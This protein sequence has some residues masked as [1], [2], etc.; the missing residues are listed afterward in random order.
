[1]YDSRNFQARP[2]LRRPEVSVVARWLRGI[3]PIVFAIVIGSN[4][5]CKLWQIRGERIAA[6][7]YPTVPNPL[8]VPACERQYIMEQVSDEID[9]YF[10]IR[11][12]ERIRLIDNILTEGSIETQPQIGSTAFEPWRKDSTRGFERRLSTL[13]TIRRWSKVRVIPDGNGYAIDVK[14]YKELEDRDPPDHSVV[15]GSLNRFDNSIDSIDSLSTN[16]AGLSI[17]DRNQLIWF[18]IGRDTELE[19][20]ILRNLKARLSKK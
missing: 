5:G 8:R 14:V 7:S 16:Q 9:N 3:L 13:Q 18:P 10:E 6:S 11:Q 12:E 20:T 1:M 19:Q 15:S 4:G 2:S 17:Q